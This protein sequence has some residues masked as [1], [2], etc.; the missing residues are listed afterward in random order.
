MRRVL[1]LIVKEHLKYD[2]GG[3]SQTDTNVDD[4]YGSVKMKAKIQ[5]PV[6]IHGF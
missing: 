1:K 6:N 4:N 2:M 5:L 3:N